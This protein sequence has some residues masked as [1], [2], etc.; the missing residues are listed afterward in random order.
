MTLAEKIFAL[1]AQ[2]PFSRLR[3]EELLVVATAATEREFE[4]G[5]VVAA[6]GGTLH[7]LLVRVGGSLLDDSGRP[8]HPVV[9][10][11]VLLTGCEVPYT[12]RAGPDG[13]RALCLPRG[14]LL[15]IVHE[16]PLLLIGFF[17]MP[18]FAA[19]SGEAPAASP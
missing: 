2:F 3:P 4:P 11:T 8:S 13:F 15:T 6:R 5:R 14:K 16:C 1:R 17:E 7:H 10:T 9:G 12:L 18:I 19:P